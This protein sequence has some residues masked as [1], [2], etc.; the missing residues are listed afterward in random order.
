MGRMN[1]ASTPVLLTVA[2]TKI[3]DVPG[4]IE[5]LRNSNDFNSFYIVCPPQA[6]AEAG[7]ILSN[8]PT[9]V[10]VIDEERVI[11]GLNAAVVSENIPRRVP[12]ASSR[13][14]ACW[15]YQ[16]FLKMGFSRF[17]SGFDYYLIWDTDTILTKRIRF[18]ERDKVLL[19][20]SEEYHRDYF[21]TIRKIL[22][23]IAIPD[24]SHI[25]QHALVRTADMSALLDELSSHGLPW[26]QYVLSSMTGKSPQQFSEYETYAAYCLSRWPERYQSVWRRWLRGGSAY[27]GSNWHSADISALADLYDYIAF[28]GWDTGPR[29]RRQTRLR[30][31]KDRIAQ[32]SGRN[33]GWTWFPK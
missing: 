15:Y 13:S 26:W 12:G 20:A 3:H 33:F 16:Q 23:R 21:R 30:V 2:A 11:P 29:R 31:M 9:G 7:Q 1:P 27:F 17:V 18:Y 28:E 32:W 24:R 14:L 10:Q 4:V 8:G 25:S 6:V 19:T 5:S 22:P